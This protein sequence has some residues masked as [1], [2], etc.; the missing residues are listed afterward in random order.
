VTTFRLSPLRL[1]R[2]PATVHS[3]ASLPQAYSKPHSAHLPVPV[4]TAILPTTLAAN[5]SHRS[6]LTQPLP[7]NPPPPWYLFLPS[8]PSHFPSVM[9]SLHTYAL[10]TPPCL[11]TDS[12]SGRCTRCLSPSQRPY[13]LSTSTPPT[14]YHF[15]PLPSY[16]TSSL[17]SGSTSI[18]ITLSQ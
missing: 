5:H 8:L 17:L 15:G 2:S 13:S 14:S 3:S 1:R 18:P 11:P 10:Y 7:P 16:S 4:C 12:N 9:T 6:D